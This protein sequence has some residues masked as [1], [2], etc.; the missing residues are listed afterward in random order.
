[1]RQSNAGFAN[2]SVAVVV[3]TICQYHCQCHCQYR[4][5]KVIGPGRGNYRDSSVCD[6]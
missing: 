6:V 1:V 4:C 2:I 3:T 5:R